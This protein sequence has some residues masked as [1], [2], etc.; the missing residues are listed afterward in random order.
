MI[1]ILVI[2]SQGQL[3][4]CLM[5]QAKNEK[6]KIIFTNRGDIDMAD[7]N[8]INKKLKKYRPSIV[9]NASAYTDTDAAEE[10]SEM[11]FL[12][13][14]D[15]VQALAD[16]C[17]EINCILIHISTDFVFDGLSSEPYREDDKT[18]PIN[19][20]GKSKLSGE[21]AI[22]L[23]GCKS[24]IIR[25]SWVFSEHGSNFLKTMLRHGSDK[26]EMRIV[27]NQIGCPT[28]AQDIAKI[29][30]LLI[31]KLNLDQP[32][33]EIYNY[34]GDTVCSWYQFATYIFYEAN[35]LG[36]ITPNFISPINSS[37][38]NRMIN[39]PNYSVLNCSKI[40]NDFSIKQSNLK[41]AIISSLKAIRR[42]NI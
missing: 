5:N 2:G 38:Y 3:G 35:K 8:T 41:L 12:I 36:F 39:V 17:A 24:I 28:Y 4:T 22:K 30:F 1:K 18:S 40:N 14:S 13:N 6:N 31:S 27:D 33:K 42:E 37:D 19:I 10:N 15:G 21:N 23:S 20:Y 7:K 11:A 26:N 34:C 9:I 32:Y 29:I 25:T 16:T